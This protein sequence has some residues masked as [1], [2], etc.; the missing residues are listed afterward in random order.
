MLDYIKRFRNTGVI[1]AIA[2]L[3]ANLL[4]QFGIK[5]DVQ[6]VNNTVLIICNILVVL[7]ICNNPTEKGLDIPVNKTDKAE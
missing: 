7:G 2:G 4:I 6:W 1:I 5:C 3:V